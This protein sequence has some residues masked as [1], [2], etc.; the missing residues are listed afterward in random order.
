MNYR[1]GRL[2]R[3][4]KA[5][6]ELGWSLSVSCWFPNQCP[7]NSYC[8]YMFIGYVL[9]SVRNT[10]LSY[11]D[12][13]TILHNKT[14]TTLFQR[15]LET[16]TKSMSI[17]R[18]SHQDFHS[19][20]RYPSVCTFCRHCRWQDVQES[21]GNFVLL[22]SSYNTIEIFPPIRSFKPEFTKY[23]ADALEVVTEH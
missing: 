14:K 12:T 3:L 21:L 10:N 16:L 4:F 22:L 18:S 20:D 9:R 19:S 15:I 23:F 8:C 1:N 2:C 6:A 17:K 7:H 5:E 11:H 13:T